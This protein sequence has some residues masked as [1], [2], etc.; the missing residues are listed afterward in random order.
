MDKA[1]AFG[2]IVT[3]LAFWMIYRIHRRPRDLTLPPPENSTLRTPDWRRYEL[4][5]PRKYIP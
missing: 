4:H 5:T 3:L 1:L 2:A